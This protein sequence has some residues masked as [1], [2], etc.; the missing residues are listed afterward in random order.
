MVG[1]PSRVVSSRTN[2]VLQAW[3]GKADKMFQEWPARIMSRKYRK[4]GPVSSFSVFV[5][6]NAVI[7][8]AREPVAAISAFFSI[9]T[10]P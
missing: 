1:R 6:P 7:T 2:A 10:P 5:V 3:C 9:Q 8:P 4:L